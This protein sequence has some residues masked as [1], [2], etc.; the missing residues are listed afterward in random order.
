MKKENF[1]YRFKSSQSPETVFKLLQNIEQWWSGVYEETIKGKS[2]QLNDEFTFLAGGGAHY[3]RQKLV[4]LV[5]AKRIAWLVTESKLSFLSKPDEWTGTTI[6]FDLSAD[7][8]GTSVTFTH[9]GLTPQIECY[10]ACSSGWTSYLG[11]L[12]EKL[13]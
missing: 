6:S 3:S 13:K 5:P 12:K 1:V 4:E 8:S 11:N 9:E 7:G 10:D 2:D